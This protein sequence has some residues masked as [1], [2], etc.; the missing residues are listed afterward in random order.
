MDCCLKKRE[1][2]ECWCFSSDGLN[3]VSQDEVVVVLRRKPGENKV[4]TDIFHYY[5][6]LYKAAVNGWYFT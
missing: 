1:K 2:N 3:T 5:K 4:P 6:S